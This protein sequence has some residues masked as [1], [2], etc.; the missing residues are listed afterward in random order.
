MRSLRIPMTV[1]GENKLRLELQ[2]LKSVQRPR[3]IEAISEAR[4]QGDLKENAEYHFAREQQ[5]LI[6]CKIKD[7][8]V[9][10]SNAQIIDIKKINN[11]GT[12]TFGAT[13]KLLNI[14]TSK[15]TSYKIVGED[16]ANIKTQLI[17]IS[18]PLSRALIGKAKNENVILNTP[19]G[20]VKYKIISIDYI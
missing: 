8:E 3:I 17:S 6:E 12:V 1:Y 20:E 5:S 10:L 4:K 9:K 15:N 2:E 16:E 19:T 11:M 7:T 13:V 14:E 18:S